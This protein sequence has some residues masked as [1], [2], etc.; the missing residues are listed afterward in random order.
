MTDIA[1]YIHYELY[2]TRASNSFI[3]FILIKISTLQQF[4]Y[5]GSFYKNRQERF[6]VYKNFLIVYE[7]QE[8]EKIVKIKTIVNRRM[9]R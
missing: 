9:A 8:K 5:M 2:N 6:I 1:L 3:N 7:I 4:P